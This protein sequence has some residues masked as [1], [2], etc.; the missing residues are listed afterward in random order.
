MRAQEGPFSSGPNVTAP[1]AWGRRCG[2]VTTFRSRENPTL[3]L[4]DH[5]HSP[6]KSPQFTGEGPKLTKNVHKK[7]EK[8]DGMQPPR[9]PDRQSNNSGPGGGLL[10]GAA[11]LCTAQKWRQELDD[12]LALAPRR[13]SPPMGTLSRG[14]AVG[15]AV[16]DDKNEDKSR[17]RSGDG[18]DLSQ[19]YSLNNQTSSVTRARKPPPPPPLPTHLNLSAAARHAIAAIAL[20]RNCAL[21]GEMESCGPKMAASKNKKAASRN[22]LADLHAVEFS[23]TSEEDQT[24]KNKSLGKTLVVHRLPQTHY[25]DEPEPHG[26]DSKTGGEQHFRT[27]ND[28][29]TWV[30]QHYRT[31]RPPS[32]VNGKPEA[33]QRRAEKIFF[34]GG[35]EFER[36]NHKMGSIESTTLLATASVATPTAASAVPSTVVSVVPSTAA[37]AVPSTATTA[38][39]SSAASV[40]PSTAA[41]VLQSTA[42]SEVP[43]PAA[44]AVPSTAISV[45]PSTIVSVAPSPSFSK[46][47]I[48]AAGAKDDVADVCSNDGPQR[49]MRM[50]VTSV[51]GYRDM[52]RRLKHAQLNAGAAGRDEKVGAKESEGKYETVTDEPFSERMPSV[53]QPCGATSSPING[54]NSQTRGQ[55]TPAIGMVIPISCPSMWTGQEWSDKVRTE[56]AVSS[57]QNTDTTMFNEHKKNHVSKVDILQSN[58]DSVT[59]LIQG[60]DNHVCN[61]ALQNGGWVGSAN[62]HSTAMRYPMNTCVINLTNVNAEIENKKNHNKKGSGNN[63]QSDTKGDEKP[64]IDTE[65]VKT[66]IVEPWGEKRTSSWHLPKDERGDNGFNLCSRNSKIQ[67]NEAINRMAKNFLE[68][69]TEMMKNKLCR[70]ESILDLPV[71][72]LQPKLGTKGNQTGNNMPPRGRSGRHSH[73]GGSTEDNQDDECEAGKTSKGREAVEG[74]G[75]KGVRKIRGYVTGTTAGGTDEVAVE[76]GEVSPGGRNWDVKEGEVPSKMKEK[77]EGKKESGKR[78]KWTDGFQKGN[79]P[80]KSEPG[81][82]GNGSTGEMKWPKEEW[83]EVSEQPYEY[84]HQATSR[85]GVTSEPSIG[86]NVRQPG[87]PGCERVTDTFAGDAMHEYN[88]MT[89]RTSSHNSKAYGQQRNNVTGMMTSSRSSGAD[90]D[91]RVHDED[92]PQGFVPRTGSPCQGFQK[93]TNFVTNNFAATKNSSERPTLTNAQLTLNAVKPQKTGKSRIVPSPTRITR[94]PNV[95]PNREGRNNDHLKEGSLR[96]ESSSNQPVN[97]MTSIFSKFQPSIITDDGSVS[98]TKKIDVDELKTRVANAA[99]GAGGLSTELA[100]NQGTK[101]ANKTDNSIRTSNTGAAC[102]D[103][104][105][106]SQPRSGPES[107]KSQEVRSWGIILAVVVWVATVAVVVWVTTVAVVVWVTTWQWWYG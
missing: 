12:V 77:A 34:S 88:V 44:S 65:R 87:A 93:K 60:D 21:V 32:A 45:T 47:P 13:P 94:L 26:V 82:T 46:N 25:N 8:N 92:K 62:T 54:I 71:P 29:Q 66:S 36:T 99:V 104:L 35:G 95:A 28:S 78:E 53:T 10:G 39:P 4:A 58:S 74:V 91:L 68:M 50:G 19:K 79:V 11:P 63:D 49:R 67:K 107:G 42:A 18:K 57:D 56:R 7:R 17:G 86:S 55:D 64:I 97:E 5:N 90:K 80:E 72:S 75:E 3:N 105:R 23:F 61:T 31:P 89:V 22:K 15:D 70:K 73:Y 48:S 30:E 100:A 16:N 20:R 59:C 85:I 14:R 76:K 101:S 106:K 52:I 33:P 24:E 2:A 98:L 9:P 6:T 102:R 38:V 103:I 84:L 1:D 43:L 81:R 40:V 51:E 27:P 96:H 41:S 83:I 69:E 37:S